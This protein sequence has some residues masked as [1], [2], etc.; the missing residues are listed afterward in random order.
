[1]KRFLSYALVLIAGF[2]GGVLTTRSIANSQAKAAFETDLRAHK[3]M[4]I[5]LNGNLKTSLTYQR[6]FARFQERLAASERVR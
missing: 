3:L 1:M 5:D 4:P 2:A 6:G